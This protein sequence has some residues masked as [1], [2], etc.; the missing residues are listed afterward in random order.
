MKRSEINRILREAKKFLRQHRFHL[1]PFA[2]WSPQDWTKKGREAEAIVRC[3]LG[4]D[5]TDFGRGNFSRC[6][7]FLFTLRNGLPENLQARQG[8]LYAEKIMIV[9]KDQVTPLHF[10]RVK[11]EDIINRGGGR[12]LVQLYGSDSQEKLSESPVT[13]EVDGIR[14]TIPAGG[15]VELN[16]GESVT[17]EPFC[18][19]QFWGEGADVL[20][21]EVSL[22]NDDQNDNR[23]FEPVGRFPKI[24]EDAP[25]MHLLCTDYSKFDFVQSMKH[26]K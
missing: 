4:W 9:R 18:Y 26:Q 6:G 23:F 19:H 1:P 5:I 10:H 21:G 7:L 22:V 17:L 16:P 13:A 24:E 25:P 8:K 15:T 11:M 20:V 2:F 14:R 3:Q 12:L